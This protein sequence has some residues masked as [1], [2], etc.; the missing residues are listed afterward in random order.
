MAVMLQEDASSLPLRPVNHHQNAHKSRLRPELGI[1]Y[2][3]LTKRKS[4][5]Q[6]LML[7]SYLRVPNSQAFK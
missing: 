7:R 6:Y 4:F 1:K 5:L 2:K 3:V